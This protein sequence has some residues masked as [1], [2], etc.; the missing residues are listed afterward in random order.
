MEPVPIILF[1]LLLGAVIFIEK[2]NNELL[3]YTQ[4]ELF[5]CVMEFL[6]DAFKTTEEE[7]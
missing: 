1:M 5:R 6:S 4:S 2:A 3:A 7:Q